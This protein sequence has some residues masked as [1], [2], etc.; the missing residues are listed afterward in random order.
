MKNESKQ[1]EKYCAISMEMISD[2]EEVKIVF[3]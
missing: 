3:I 2:I 1:I